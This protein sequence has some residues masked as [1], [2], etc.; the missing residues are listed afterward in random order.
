LSATPPETKMTASGAEPEERGAGEF[1]RMSQRSRPI[2]LALLALLAAAPIS[3]ADAACADLSGRFDRSVAA[4]SPGEIVRAFQSVDDDNACG[5]NRHDYTQRAIAAVIARLSA[6]PQTP[7]QDEV[8]TWILNKLQ[9]G[10]GDWRS[11]E[12]LGQYFDALG[13]H[14][15]AQLSYGAAI[16]VSGRNFN[17]VASDND[18]KTL[19]NEAFAAQSLASDDDQG[20]ND[21][22]L[23]PS[24]RAADGGVGG[25]Y[26]T[27]NR[28][29]GVGKLPIPVNFVYD[30][31]DLT[32]AGAAA[33]KE[34]AEVVMQLE[35]DNF[36]LIGH[37]DPRGDA[38][39]NQKLSLARAQALAQTVKEL[40]R[41]SPDNYLSKHKMPEIATAGKGAA[42]PYDASFLTYRPS[43]EDIWQLDRRVEFQFSGQ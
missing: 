34:L 42:E 7:A 38:N 26:A 24:P 35:L 21:V 17:D 3:A 39:Y 13:D 16:A 25:A 9:D 27:L 8:K 41:G 37:A 18:L 28:Q 29:V 14:R 4:G 43:Q 5:F 30:S 11:A 1:Q 23:A 36:T 12:R 32:K 10:G 33:A 40:I 20:R 19:A 22:A 31:T 2:P 6:A 15:D